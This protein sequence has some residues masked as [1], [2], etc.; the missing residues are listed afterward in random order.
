MR[1][2]PAW[3][4]PARA[5]FSWKG[6]T[7]AAPRTIFSVNE[8]AAAEVGLLAPDNRDEAVAYALLG[9]VLAEPV[10]LGLRRMAHEDQS[11]TRFSA[12]G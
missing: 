2:T 6:G 4:W 12:R 7:S 8:L 11:R 5:N 10:I 9:S 3:A 1:S